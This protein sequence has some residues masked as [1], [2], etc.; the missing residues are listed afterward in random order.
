M[1]NPVLHF[2]IR[3]KD[4][5]HLKGFY[6]ELFGW[7]ITTDNPMNYGLIE[8]EPRAQSA[9][10]CSRT[11]RARRPSSTSGSTTSRP[12]SPGSRPRVGRPLPRRPRRQAW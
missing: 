2:E 4:A 7:T 12:T 9:A 10:G 5:E 1:G 3:G 6:A 11:R 8:P